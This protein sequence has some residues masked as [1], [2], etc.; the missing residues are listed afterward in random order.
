VPVNGE[1]HGGRRGPRL[2]A[3]RRKGVR[4]RANPGALP[5]S[6][7]WGAPVTARRL[8]P[9]R[10]TGQGRSRVLPWAPDI[11][12]PSHVWAAGATVRI[13]V[14]RGQHRVY[15]DGG[16]IKSNAT[17]HAHGRCPSRRPPRRPRAGRCGAA[18]AAVRGVPARGRAGPCREGR[19]RLD[20][21][22]PVRLERAAAAL[23][24]ARGGRAFTP[25]RP[26]HTGG[27][28]SRYARHLRTELDLPRV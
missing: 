8:A 10:G 18:R 17:A 22:R 25:G 16:A 21:W 4:R 9:A 6:L 2:S 7:N 19:R 23:C 11:A 28:H 12:I 5:R 20:L 26:T 24:R 13:G 15:D 14:A 27:D 1:S 3:W